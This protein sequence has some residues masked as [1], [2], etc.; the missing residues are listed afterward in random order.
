MQFDRV[1]QVF[2]GLGFRSGSVVLYCEIDGTLGRWDSR[3][4]FRDRADRVMQVFDVC[5][6]AFG[7]R[8]VI[9]GMQC[10]DTLKWMEL[11]CSGR[12]MLMRSKL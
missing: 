4:G 10:G 2:G 12:I 6:A 3:L 9:V 11:W 7:I 5:S 8:R 1:L